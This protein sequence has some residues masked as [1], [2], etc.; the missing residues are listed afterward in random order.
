MPRACTATDVA[1]I[2]ATSVGDVV[3]IDVRPSAHFYRCHIKN[4]ANLPC[5][6]QVVGAASI[7]EAIAASDDINEATRQ[8]VQKMPLA[9]DVIVYDSGGDGGSDSSSPSTQLAAMIESSFSTEVV[10][11]AGGFKAFME[12]CPRLCVRPPSSTGHASAR[13]VID[14]TPKGGPSASPATCC[15]ELDGGL[16]PA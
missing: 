5:T 4:A 2:L 16:S 7:E 12:A 1:E 6:P 11:L 10:I 3:I 8:A 15:L 9:E 13:G 14:L